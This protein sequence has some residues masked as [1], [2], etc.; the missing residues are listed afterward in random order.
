MAAAFSFRLALCSTRSSVFA[1]LHDASMLLSSADQKQPKTCLTTVILWRSAGTSFWFA[2]FSVSY[3]FEF[4]SLMFQIRR[5]RVG[6]STRKPSRFKSHH[7]SSVN[8]CRSP[9]ATPPCKDVMVTCQQWWRKES[10]VTMELHVQ[11]RPT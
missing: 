7:S 9:S 10:T 1:T 8:D 3:Q 2:C 4:R 5:R 11:P 6:S